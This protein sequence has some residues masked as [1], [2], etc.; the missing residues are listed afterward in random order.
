MRKLSIAL[1]VALLVILTGCA[2]LPTGQNQLL[3]AATAIAL[4]KDSPIGVKLLAAAIGATVAGNVGAQAQAHAQ[5]TNPC[6][7]NPGYTYVVQNGKPTCV[8]SSAGGQYGSY[9]SGE[10]PAI[11]R[12]RAIGQQRAA[13][14]GLREAAEAAYVEACTIGGGCDDNRTRRGRSFVPTSVYGN[15]PGVVWR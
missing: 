12:A 3:G 4:T 10:H 5:A 8:P 15:N 7:Q 11:T 14:K 1:A 2:G 6:W 9:G 13:Q